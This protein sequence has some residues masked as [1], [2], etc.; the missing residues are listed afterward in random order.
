MGHPADPF[1]RCPFLEGFWRSGERIDIAI[2]IAA[3]R[4]GRVEIGDQLHR[5]IDRLQFAD[6]GQRVLDFALGF[7]GIAEHEG[8]LRN[9]A[10]LARA[11]GDFEGLLGGDALFHLLKDF[12]AAGFGPAEHHREARVLQPPPCLVGKAQ[13]R[14]DTGLAPPAQAERRESVGDGARMCIVQEEIVVVEVQ[15]IHAVFAREES[16]DAR[17]CGKG[18]GPVPGGRYTEMTPQK[19]QA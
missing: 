11:R 12:V 17:R 6:K 8:E 5:G 15:G 14:I 19:L 7:L 9:D 13:Q 16:R 18:P 3:L 1:R 2:G 10:V 4:R